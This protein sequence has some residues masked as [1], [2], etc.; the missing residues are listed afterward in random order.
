MAIEFK[1]ENRVHIYVETTKLFEI[2]NTGG[3]GRVKCVLVGT[4]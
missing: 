4:K 2:N 3:L 1:A